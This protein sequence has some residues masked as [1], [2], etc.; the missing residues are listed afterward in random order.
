MQ[1]VRVLAVVGMLG[2]VGAANA[3][4]S[5]TVTATND[6]VFRGITQ[7]AEDPAFQASIDYAHESGWYIGAWGSNVDFGPGDPANVEVDLYTG[8]AGE[9][10][11]GMGWDVGITYYT[12]PDESDY[13]YPEIYGKLSYGIFSGSLYYS[14]DWL[15]AGNDAMY[16]NAGI[17]VPFADAFTF[18]ASIGFSFGDGFENIDVSEAQDGSDLRDTEYTDYS[19]GIGYTIGNFELGLAWTDT[20][21][22]RGDPLFSDTDVANSEGRVVFTMVTTFPWGSD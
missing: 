10:E 4:V 13:N 7:T 6:Y 19:I 21:L 1:Y 22:K 17:S 11:A 14:N 2:F 18:N 20:D 8:F 5:A 15:N 3:Q 9:T 16:V 12:Y